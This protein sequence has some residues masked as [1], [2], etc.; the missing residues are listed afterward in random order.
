[1]R[2][3]DTDLPKPLLELR[4]DPE[5]GIWFIPAASWRRGGDLGFQGLI[6]P[7]CI[8]GLC[9]STNIGLLIAENPGEDKDCAL[10]RRLGIE[11]FAREAQ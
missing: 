4:E 1:M 9:A 2:A 3:A 10:F 8:K 7:G 6:S 11:P 5:S